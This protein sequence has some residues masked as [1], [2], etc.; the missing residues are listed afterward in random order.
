MI[1][2]TS[3]FNVWKYF[4]IEVVQGREKSLVYWDLLK[5]PVLFALFC[6][7]STG[8][9]ASPV[10]GMGGSQASQEVHWLYPR[11]TSTNTWVCPLH[12]FFEG[13]FGLMDSLGTCGCYLR[14]SCCSNGRYF[15]EKTR[16]DHE[17]PKGSGAQRTD[18]FWNCT[19]GA[20][21]RAAGWDHQ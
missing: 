14:L 13:F 10:T 9:S 5:L 21:S 17:L 2:L 12:F 19:H 16:G 7:I 4:Q 18:W 3:K 6:G 11:E 8:V 1:C 15:L 20:Y